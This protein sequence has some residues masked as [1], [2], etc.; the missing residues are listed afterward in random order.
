[1]STNFRTSMHID[2]VCRNKGDNC[3]VLR[4]YYILGKKWTYALIYKMDS[5]R[6]YS[7][8]EFYRFARRKINRT[9]LSNI[10]KELIYL[11]ILVKTDKKYCLTKKGMKIKSILN[12]I[13]TIFIDDCGYIRQDIKE[14]CIINNFLEKYKN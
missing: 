13:K 9:M 8:E 14:D 11:K 7:F 5:N 10:L 1:M 4:F 6:K 3:D 12:K 2:N